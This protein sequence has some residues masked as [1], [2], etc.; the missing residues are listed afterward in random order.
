MHALLRVSK[1]LPIGVTWFLKDHTRKWH[2]KYTGY[3]WNVRRQGGSQTSHCAP[4]S[5]SVC[6]SFALL[7]L[8]E[9]GKD[10]GRL[11]SADF[12]AD[13]A[14]P[15][16][17]QGAATLPVHLQ[18]ET[19]SD[20]PSDGTPGWVMGVPPTEADQKG[21][22]WVDLQAGGWASVGETSL[23]LGALLGVQ[24]RRGISLVM[25]A[26]RVEDVEDKMKSLLF[27]SLLF[28][29]GPWVFSNVQGQDFSSEKVLVGLL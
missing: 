9:D 7:P 3:V 24:R 14:P 23:S 17:G 12:R 25:S 19:R 27:Q 10:A 18:R 1:N 11:L 5:C 2:F 21:W 15:H 29:R 13:P 22:L 20:P 8:P 6:H 16:R 26:S 28:N 4:S